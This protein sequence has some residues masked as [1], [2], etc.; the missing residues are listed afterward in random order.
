M[1]NQNLWDG[2]MGDNIQDVGGSGFESFI[3]DGVDCMDDLEVPPFCLSNDIL[4]SMDVDPVWYT[5]LSNALN[6][7]LLFEDLWKIANEGVTIVFCSC[8]EKRG[9]R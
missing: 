7:Q 2:L 6:L 8:V 5:Q 4:A 1:D 9:Y 3:N